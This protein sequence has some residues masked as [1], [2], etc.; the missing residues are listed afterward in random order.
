M[1]KIY[2]VDHGATKG[3]NPSDSS[4]ED[5]VRKK[6]RV[7][8]S[9]NEEKFDN[10]EASLSPCLLPACPSSTADV[11]SAVTKDGVSKNKSRGEMSMAVAT[12]VDNPKK[13]GKQPP[14]FLLPPP[15]V[16]TYK[17]LVVSPDNKPAYVTNGG[18]IGKG[19]YG[20]YRSVETGVDH[21]DHDNFFP[22]Q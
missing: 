11:A 7:Y 6:R 18:G 5:F 16:A 12:V 22:F 8:Q 3:C 9:K 10:D 20:E 21:D 13:L 1:G 4:D 2:N 15:N 19:E 17:I 14:P